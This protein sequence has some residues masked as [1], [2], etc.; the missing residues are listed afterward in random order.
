[1]EKIINQEDFEEKGGSSLLE[2]C[3]FAPH[4][5]GTVEVHVPEG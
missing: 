2:T 1:M 5:R 4:N 3:V